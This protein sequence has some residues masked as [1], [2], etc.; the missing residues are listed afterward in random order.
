MAVVSS[1]ESV[2]DQLSIVH[3]CS[4]TMSIS[5]AVCMHI[6]HPSTDQVAYVEIMLALWQQHSDDSAHHADSQATAMYLHVVC[7]EVCSILLLQLTD[8]QSRA[9]KQG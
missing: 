7:A 3:T 9:H 5:H 1:I 6:T 8:S 4:M 2:N